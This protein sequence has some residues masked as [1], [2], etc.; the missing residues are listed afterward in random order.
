MKT[1]NYIGNVYSLRNTEIPKVFLTPHH[2]RLRQQGN[3]GTN[4]CN[5]YVKDNN[6]IQH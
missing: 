2:M 6:G 1:A 4:K 3:Q 5:N